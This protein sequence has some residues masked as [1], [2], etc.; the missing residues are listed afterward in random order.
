MNDYAR[1]LFAELQDS[2]AFNLITLNNIDAGCIFRA[3]AACNHY[4]IIHDALLRGSHA[5]DLFD[6]EHRFENDLLLKGFV[7]NDSICRIE[8]TGM[9]RS[10]EVVAQSFDERQLEIDIGIGKIAD[11]DLNRTLPDLVLAQAKLAWT[12]IAE[13]VIDVVVKPIALSTIGVQERGATQ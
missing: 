7:T 2:G 12:Y 5:G 3:K 8:I 13:Q 6:D 10:S 1:A 11:F 9:T 4:N